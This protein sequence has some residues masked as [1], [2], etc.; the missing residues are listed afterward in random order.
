MCE[1][2]AHKED[3]IATVGPAISFEIYEVGD[4]FRAHFLA[5]HPGN[6]RFFIKPE[7]AKKV[8]LIFSPMRFIGS[9]LLA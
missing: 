5:D 6:E 2:G 3:I 1:I 9:K 4:E 7:G 8:I